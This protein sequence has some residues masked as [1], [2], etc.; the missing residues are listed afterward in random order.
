[1]SYN[2]TP[3][4]TLLSRRRFEVVDVQRTWAAD[5]N[6]AAFQSFADIS[7][8]HCGYA[9]DMRAHIALYIFIYIAK[10]KL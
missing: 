9:L 4:G 3:V 6:T 2:M 5:D 1:M 7:G 10:G 8:E